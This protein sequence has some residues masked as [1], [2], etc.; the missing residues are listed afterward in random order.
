[1]ALLDIRTYPDPVLRQR[2]SDVTVFDDAL[3][4]LA[5]NMAETMYAAPGVGL[6]APQ[7][8]VSKRFLVVDPNSGD[9]ESEGPEFYVNPV[10]KSGHG[11]IICEEGCLSL[12]DFF[13]DVKRKEFIT[14]AYQDLEGKA[15]E[16]EL[17]GF[18]AVVLQHEIDHLEGVLAFDHISRLKRSLYTKR[19]KREARQDVMRI[20]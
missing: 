13:E 5:E 15:H 19:R 20:S 18:H 1:M 3:K 14:L 11:E 10:I 2:A 7:V 9:P 16:I 6:A 12:P 17:E 4:T 8:G